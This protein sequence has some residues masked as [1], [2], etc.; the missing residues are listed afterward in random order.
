MR[1]G[2]GVPDDP[3]GLLPIGTPEPGNWHD[4]VRLALGR[5]SFPLGTHA[6]R[7]SRQVA[8]MPL[9]AISMRQWALVLRYAYRFRRQIPP[10]LVPARHLVLLLPGQ[11]PTPPKRIDCDAAEDAAV[12][13]PARSRSGRAARRRGAVAADVQLPARSSSGRQLDFA[14]IWTPPER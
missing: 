10:D 14:E 3:S 2:S 5:C 7:F 13:L 12:Q 8:A 4:R 1:S 6:N 9:G 11:V